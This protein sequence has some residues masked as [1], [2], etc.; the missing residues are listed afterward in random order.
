MV[1]PS[2][3]RRHLLTLLLFP[4][5]AGGEP[6]LN[7]DRAALLALIIAV[8]KTSLQWN[9]T[10]SPCTWQGVG[11]LHNRVVFLRLPAVGLTGEIPVGTLGN[12]TALRSL[13]L[14]F[15]SLSGRL[16]PDLTGAAELRYLYLQDNRFSSEIPP[17]LFSLQNLIRLNLA[18]NGFTGGISP[19]FKNLSRLETLY[20]ESNQLIGGI[21]DLDLPKLVQFNVSFNRLNGSVPSKLWKIPSSAFIGTSLCGGPLHPCPGEISPVLASAVAESGRGSTLS[22]GAIAG[23]VVGLVAV[24]VMLLIFLLFV[25]CRSCG[26]NNGAQGGAGKQ[27]E[28]AA[29][30]RKG[31]KSPAAEK[32][33]EVGKRLVF[34]GTAGGPEF[35]LEDLLRASAEVLGKG[36]FGTAYKA[37]LELGTVVVVKRLRDVSLAEEEFREKVEKVGYM[38]HENIVQLR[39]YYYSK[40]EKLLVYDYMPMG[41]L[42]AL[43]HGNKTSRRNPLTWETRISIAL[44]VARAIDHIHSTSPTASHGNIKFSNIF[45]NESHTTRLSDNGIVP[46]VV[47]SSSRNHVSGYRAPELADSRKVSQKADVYS[48]GIVLLELL[49]GK[50]AE[51]GDNLR[52]MVESMLRE[53]WS[54]DVLDLELLR[55]Q[56]V[57]EMVQLLQ[58]AMNCT[59]RNPDSRP[60]M[61]EVI[62]QIEAIGLSSRDDGEV[63]EQQQV[64]KRQCL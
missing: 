17:V 14:R 44:S 57:E 6:D 37:E 51:E 21:P 38:K 64:V 55:Q 3:L 27:P 13:S 33:P 59:V 16:P 11:C 15:N 39:A 25:C 47:P 42:A 29:R 63:Q 58:L 7:S 26:S 22:G 28:K 45:L 54:T 20:L 31:R 12:L 8:G 24:V 48:F 35:D 19:E 30:R 5:L 52:R 32:R 56:N 18:G 10:N 53:E 43:L 36:T 50:A 40:N 1:S 34:F 23:I 41:S 49:T 61:K 46:L 62:A 4:F 9:E 2:F 60:S